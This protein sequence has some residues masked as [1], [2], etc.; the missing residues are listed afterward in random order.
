M[1]RLTSNPEETAAVLGTEHKAVCNRATDA[2]FLASNA[3]LNVEQLFLVIRGE[4]ESGGNLDKTRVVSLVQIGIDLTR[5]QGE[6]VEQQ[7]D[8]FFSEMNHV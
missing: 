3:F 6:F 7:A 5:M 1:N 8:T 2:L 4:L